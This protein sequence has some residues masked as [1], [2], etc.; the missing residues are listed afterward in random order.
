MIIAIYSV[1]TL[2]FGGGLF[3]FEAV[4]DVAAEIIKD[5]D[6]AKQVEEYTEQADD[7]FK[8]FVDN[9]DDLSKEFVELN[10]GYLVTRAEMDALSEKANQKK[11]KRCDTEGQK[12]PWYEHAKL[13]IEPFN[14]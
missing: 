2:I 8:E 10:R 4:A 3:S 6:R 1:F 11:R 9:I 12:S 13:C 14:I 7:V 5:K